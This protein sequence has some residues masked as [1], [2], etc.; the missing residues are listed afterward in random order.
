MIF[1]VLRILGCMQKSYKIELYCQK[2]GLTMHT[3]GYVVHLFQNV[4]QDQTASI[5]AVSNEIT[6]RMIETGRGVMN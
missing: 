1:G 4:N 6:S 5:H 2:G 3:N